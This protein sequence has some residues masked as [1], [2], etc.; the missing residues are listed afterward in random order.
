MDKLR[1]RARFYRRIIA[2]AAVIVAGL[3]ALSWAFVSRVSAA[4]DGTAVRDEILSMAFA[5]LAV[6]VTA[7]LVI[8]GIMLNRERRYQRER[9]EENASERRR[10]IDAIARSCRVIMEI[11]LDTDEF[12]LL[13]QQGSVEHGPAEYASYTDFWNSRRALVDGQYHHALERL[14]LEALRERRA[15]GEDGASME[16]ELTARGETHYLRVDVMIVDGRGIYM[17]RIVDEAKAE[18]K[19]QRAILEN[20]LAM[21]EHANAAKTNFLHN[22]SHDLRTPMNAIVG[23]AA[24]AAAHLEHKDQVADYLKK[25]TTAS[26]HLL[27]LINDILDMSRIESGKVKLEEKDTHLPDIFHDIRTLVQPSI[28]AKNLELFIDSLDVTNED[29]VCDKL[30]LSQVLIN[31]VGNAVKFTPAGGTIAVRVRQLPQAPEGYATYEIRVK[32]NGIGISPDFLPHI[33]EAFA[34]E[35]NTTVSKIQGTGLG[36]PICKNIVEMMGG[37][38]SVNTAQ[39]EGTE[40]TVSLTLRV[41]AAPVAVREIPELTGER[42]LVVDDDVNNCTGVAAMLKKI[43]MRPDWTLSG[44][45]A[46]LHAQYAV[47]SN[48]EYAA[49]IVDWLMPDMNGIEVVRRIRRIISR[50]KPI[51]VLTSYDWSD[52]ED[53]AREAGVTAF[54]AKPLFLSELQE[55][56]CS[57]FRPETKPEQVEEKVDFTGSHLLLVE[58]DELNQEIA[59]AILEDAGFTLDVANDGREACDIIREAEAGRYDLILMDIQMPHMNGYEATRTIRAMGA[60]LSTIPIIAMTADAFAEDRERAMEAG[61]DGHL[62][63]PIDVDALMAKL[64]ETLNKR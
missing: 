29:V 61:M 44:R 53:E 40:F 17:S 48:E 62:T 57:H 63:K 3:V 11:D 26:H 49:Y 58:D 37:T 64:A 47:D 34:R 19:K 51:I 4:L 39:G 32:D 8:A 16:L 25:I 33:F 35:R 60:P 59:T 45:E 12:R 2:I 50:D 24:M 46:L 13:Y 30:R 18:E 27:S 56:L 9:E 6:T 54:C 7:I 20:A 55:I 42:A 1:Q 36:L 15:A 10:I 41:A 21:A 5:L 52:I 22:M 38:I 23:F 31:L 14:T 43:G 28:T